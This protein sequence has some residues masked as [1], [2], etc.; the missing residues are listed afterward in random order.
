MIELGARS[1][2]VDINAKQLPNCSNCTQALEN[3]EIST[4]QQSS[5]ATCQSH[6]N[7][8][9]LI[10]SSGNISDVYGFFALAEYAKT[11]A[12]VL[13]V[14]N[15]PAYIGVQDDEVD[16]ASTKESRAEADI[17]YSKQNPGPALESFW[18]AWGA[19]CQRHGNSTRNIIIHFL[20]TIPTGSLTQT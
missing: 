4:G 6:T 7:L 10:I 16:I 12:D 3:F 11:G 14:M 17:L 13:F 9:R 15:Y 5:Y 1:D 2:L 19:L 8:T 18:R 20:A